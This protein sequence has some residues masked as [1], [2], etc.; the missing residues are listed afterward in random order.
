ML[1]NYERKLVFLMD[2]KTK[3]RKLILLREKSRRENQ[4]KLQDNFYEFCVYYDPKFYTPGKQHL[5]LIANSLQEVADGK[6]KKLAVS[7]PPRAGKSYTLSLFCAWILGKH[8]NNGSIMRNSYAA[9][10][11]EKFSKDIRDGILINPKYL[12]VFPDVKLSKKAQAV[13]GWSLE[14]NTQP[15]YFCAGVGGAITGFGCKTI[16]ILDDPIKNIEE[17]LSETVIENTWNWYTSTHLSR[18]E[19]GCAEI[20]VATRWSRKD[21]IGRLTDPNSE[22]YD[23]EFKVIVISALD[24]N[25]N[26]FCEEV[27]TTEEYMTI[28]K[29]T[30]DFIW[31]AEYMQHPVESKGL[32]YPI[33]ELNRFS[34]TEIST[35]KADGIV[36][37]T[38]TAD[39]GS[40][41]LCSVTGK[42]FG[43]HT[44]ITDV[45]FTQDGVEITEPLVAEM[46]ID[47]KMD[48]MK[49]ESNNGGSSYARN[50]RGLVKG[51]S[52]CMIVDEPTTQ[53]KETRIIMNAG[54]IKQYFYFRNDYKLG[55]DYDKYMR[56][57]TSY[58]KLG[59]N[60]HD[61]AP[62]ATTGLA[63]FM[64]YKVYSKP[65]TKQHYNFDFEKPKHDVFEPVEVDESY[66][67]M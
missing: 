44:Y 45:V 6:V 67:N 59:K 3:E 17:A 41:F 63:E 54:Y 47:T 60:V 25:G 20:H 39:K 40:D 37:F 5:K 66:I 64:K 21:P 19:T 35:K 49:I 43:E 51:K 1:T 16:A 31:E 33:E 57:L 15:S 46:I 26:S 24:D 2:R 42:R 12:E 30:D 7:L 55:S 23:P 48:L 28:K 61:D 14:E 38:D 9:K 8:Q 11:A 13:D 53:N 32:L 65:Q 52:P 27:K 4:K 22:E 62:D 56:Y 36:G 34:M 50:V 10:L 58:I 29:V 18:L